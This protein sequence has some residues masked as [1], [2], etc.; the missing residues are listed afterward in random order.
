MDF[1]VIVT[2]IFGSFVIFGGVMGYV[3]AASKA[4]LIAGS[5]TGG[6]LLL[7]AVLIANG[8]VAGAILGLV[9]SLLLIGQFG[10]SLLKKFKVM[11]NLLVVILGI[12]TVGTLAFSLFK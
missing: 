5:I 7:S 8:I 9:V 6:L 4:S 10:P 3:K 11:P 1:P 2:A 12:I